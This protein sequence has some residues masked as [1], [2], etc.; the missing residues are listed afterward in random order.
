MHG[1]WGQIQIRSKNFDNITVNKLPD[2]PILSK[3]P[4]GM[5]YT[6]SSQSEIISSMLVTPNIPETFLMK[7]IPNDVSWLQ[8]Y[9]QNVN[10]LFQ[11]TSF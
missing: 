10:V 9:Y 5:K 8:F 4:A 3:I 2:T 6:G 7:L 1:D 11:E